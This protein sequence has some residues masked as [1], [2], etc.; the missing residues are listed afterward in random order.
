MKRTQF[1]VGV[2]VDQPR[3]DNSAV[4]IDFGLCVEGTIIRLCGTDGLD[5]VFVNDDSAVLNNCPILIYWNHD[6]IVN[7]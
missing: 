2:R 1:E 6:R 7:N 4:A 5:D 3:K